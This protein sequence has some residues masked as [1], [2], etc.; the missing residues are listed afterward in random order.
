MRWLIGGLLALIGLV[1]ILGA[2][3]YFALKRPDLPYETLAAKYESAASRYADLPDGVRMHYRDEGAQ[4][5]PT[6]LL[7]HGF[8]ASLHTWEPWVQRLGEEYRI[9]SLDLPGHGLTRAPA[10]YQPSMER[11]RDDVAAFVAAQGLT[12]FAIAGSSM[13]GNVAWEYAL[14]HPD[15][16]D[17]L[18]LVDAAGWPDA[19]QDES[20]EPQI[21]KLLRNPIIGPILR[22]LDN[23]RL[24]RQGIEASFYDANLVGDAMVTRYTELARAPGH[25]DILLNIATNR[26]GRNPATAERL[27]ALDT[28]ALI[29]WGD[30]DRLVPV[31]HAQQFHDA[32]RGSQVVMFENTGHIPQEERPD[33][34]ASAVREF[35]HPI[36]EGSALAPL[37]EVNCDA[38]AR[39]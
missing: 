15:Q 16:V 12:H 6:L 23:T 9:V 36:I 21:F 27:A 38:D 10:G 24:V 20:S 13:G 31:E 30:T 28:P 32:I 34:S 39:C 4:N 25:R 2:G 7:I 19:R 1:A 3:A 22:D 11:Y 33:E 26:Q 8:S 18:I 5:G 29:L 14:A 35:L 17:A 37:P